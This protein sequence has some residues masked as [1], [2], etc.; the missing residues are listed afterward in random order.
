MNKA[1]KFQIEHFKKQYC[2]S[3]EKRISIIKHFSVEIE[4]YEELLPGKVMKSYATG[5]REMCI[6]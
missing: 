4:S 5:N 1:T 2:I 6:L 3:H